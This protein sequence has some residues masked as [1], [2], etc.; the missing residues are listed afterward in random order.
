MRHVGC[1]RAGMVRVSGGERA[2]PKQQMQG[3]GR[4]VGQAARGG[5]GGSST[6]NHA[7]PPS[8]AGVCG[9]PCQQRCDG[10]PEGGGWQWQQLDCC[11]AL[12]ALTFT[13]AVGPAGQG[14]ASSVTGRLVGATEAVL[15]AA[16][17]LG[18]DADA[19]TC[20]CTGERTGA[21]AAQGSGGVRSAVLGRATLGPHPTWHRT[22]PRLLIPDGVNAAQVSS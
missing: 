11:A 5:G 8:A 19:T 3:P 16:F 15:A 10:R 4:A 17:T 18:A 1:Q 14:I 6:A 22:S 7:L 9:I 2:G 12:T 21:Q 13:G 20:A